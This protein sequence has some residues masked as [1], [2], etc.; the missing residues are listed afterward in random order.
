MGRVAGDGKS[1]TREQ[2]R[3]IETPRGTESWVPIPHDY[4]VQQVEQTI[5]AHNLTVRNEDYLISRGGDRMFGILD[6]RSDQDEDYGLTIGVR[7]SHD[8][9]L[10]VGLL[11]GTRVFVCSNLSFGGEVRIQTKHTKFVMKRLPRLI[12]DA[13]AKLLESRQTQD[14]RI[15]AYKGTLVEKRKEAAFLMLQAIR[16]DIIPTRLVNS[17]CSEWERPSHEEFAAD[18]SAWRMFNAVTEVLKSASKLKLAE[19]TQR[20]HALMDNHCGLLGDRMV[21]V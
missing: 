2:L 14:L 6:L 8:M 20:L 18:W 12:C 1:L 19:R 15:A 5:G 13:A 10:P 7:N 4:V 9:S 11:L 16:Q 17:L 3:S 21:A